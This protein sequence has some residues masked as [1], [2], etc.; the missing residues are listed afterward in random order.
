MDDSVSAAEPVASNQPT[1]ERRLLP[2]I[3]LLSCFAIAV[4]EVSQ[5]DVRFCRRDK[6]YICC[7]LD[8][9]FWWQ[10]GDGTE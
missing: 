4:N 8:E 2:D 6:I 10:S 5:R 3:N 9:R 1:T 7:G